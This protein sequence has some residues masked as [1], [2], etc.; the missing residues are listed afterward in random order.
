MGLFV[1]SDKG[2]EKAA[3]REAEDLIGEVLAEMGF[4]E[5]ADRAGEREGGGEGEASARR[6]DEDIE[7]D[8]RAELEGMRGQDGEK[9]TRIQN[10]SRPR[11][12]NEDTGSAMRLGLVTLDI[13]CVSF[14]RLPLTSTS[15]SSSDITSVIDPVDLVY[16]IT[17]QAY[18]EPLR[19]RS[20]F[21]KRLTPL[22]RVRKFLNEGLERLCDEVLPSVFGKE[23]GKEWKYAIRVTVRNNSKVS[24][25]EIIKKVAGLV[26]A[27]GMGQDVVDND[28]GGNTSS[29]GEGEGEGVEQGEGGNSKASPTKALEHKVDLKNFEKLVMVDVYRNVV[30]MSVVGEAREFEDRLRRF[31]LSEIYSEGRKKADEEKEATKDQ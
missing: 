3:L 26:V 15:T 20:R 17:R 30:G 18:L 14:V 5:K 21:I 28:R 11:P 16:R 22:T 25:D 6:E 7:K 24:R 13:P 9:G 8:I 4:G 1:T 23:Q 29:E 27:S 19:P 31:N 12:N 10:A 2:K